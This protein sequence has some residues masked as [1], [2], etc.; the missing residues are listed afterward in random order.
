MSKVKCW[1]CGSVTYT[2]DNRHFTRYILCS[3]CADELNEVGD[4]DTYEGDPNPSLDD[5]YGVLMYG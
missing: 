4:E 5:T 3:E 2:Q 1:K